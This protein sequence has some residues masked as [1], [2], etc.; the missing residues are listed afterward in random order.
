ML[1]FTV[2]LSRSNIRL[3]I[4]LFFIY[5]CLIVTQEQEG[6]NYGSVLVW[7]QVN[8][9]RKGWIPPLIRSLSRGGRLSP[10]ESI[11]KTRK[12]GSSSFQKCGPCRER[13]MKLV[14][15][16]F[17]HSAYASVVFREH[18]NHRFNRWILQLTRRSGGTNRS[19]SCRLHGVNRR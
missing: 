8:R 1:H 3:W 19:R 12:C 16:S 14:I 15:V 13:M 5:S 11:S 10:P 2:F 18:D 7:E 4:E 17:D 6:T 9:I